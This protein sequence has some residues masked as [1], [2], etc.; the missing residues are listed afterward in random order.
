[1]ATLAHEQARRAGRRKEEEDEAALPDLEDDGTGYGDMDDNGFEEAGVGANANFGFDNHDSAVTN[2]GSENDDIRLLVV[3]NPVAEEQDLL[4][5]EVK[6]ANHKGAKR[7]LKPQV[8][9]PILY[10]MCSES[11]LTNYGSTILLLIVVFPTS[12][13]ELNNPG[14][15]KPDMYL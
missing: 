1:M 2:L 12:I 6:L 9:E 13:T 11:E 14:C 8:N 10:H 5:M 3:Q 4:A 7:R 15:N